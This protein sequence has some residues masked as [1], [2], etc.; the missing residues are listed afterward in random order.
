MDEFGSLGS[1]EELESN[2]V[3]EKWGILLRITKMPF[4]NPEGIIE[5]A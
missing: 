4:R 5:S 1:D 3:P 2:V